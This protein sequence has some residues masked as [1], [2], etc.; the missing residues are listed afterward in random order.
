M[1]I[2]S[3]II[4]GAVNFAEILEFML[5]GYADNLT[6]IVVSKIIQMLYLALYYLNPEQYVLTD[7]SG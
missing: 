6:D 7:L 5:G 3:E 4:S 2:E 1:S